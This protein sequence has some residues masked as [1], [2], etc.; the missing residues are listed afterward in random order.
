MAYGSHLNFRDPD[1]DALELSTS[2]EVVT[3]RFAEL[4]ERELPQEEIRARLDAYL[5]S[6]RESQS[7]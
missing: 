2:N 1:N 4:R 7:T 6:V 5:A 3:A